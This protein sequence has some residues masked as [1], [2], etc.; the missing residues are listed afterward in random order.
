MANDNDETSSTTTAT[1]SGS[2]CDL[3]RFKSLDFFKFNGLPRHITGY[4]AS[5]TGVIGTIILLLIVGGYIVNSTVRFFTTPPQTSVTQNPTLNQIHPFV[6]TCITV[7]HLND[8]TYFARS[9]WR[10]TLSANGTKST[11]LLNL[12]ETGPDTVCFTG[13]N[14]TAAYVRG[15]CRP[16]SCDF[17]RFKLWNCGCPDVN[18]FNRNQSGCVPVSTI[19][20][21]LANNYVDVRYRTDI[22]EVVQ[23]TAPKTEASAVYITTFALN[24]TQINPDLLRSFTTQ[25][26]SNLIYSRETYHLQYFFP[27]NVPTKEVLELQMAMDSHILI[28]VENRQTALDMIGSWGAFFSVIASVGAI[29]FGTY[30]EKKFYEKNPKWESIDE[31]FKVEEGSDASLQNEASKLLAGESTH[32]NLFA[33][34]GG[35]QNGGAGGGFGRISNANTSR[36]TTTGNNNNRRGGGSDNN[37]LNYSQ[38]ADYGG[39]LT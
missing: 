18:N 9:L 5:I 31:D 12:T 3:K 35:I 17:L 10:V 22:A 37:R 13:S 33:T 38:H 36:S 21:I 39:V 19:T 2:R 25:Y 11:T 4:Q 30:N 24:K 32:A 1:K 6:S 23:H 14:D 16:G 28:T 26:L 15:F 8:P 29:V 34:G 27:D 7:P 20:D